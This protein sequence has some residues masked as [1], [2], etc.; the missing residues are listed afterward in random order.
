[1]YNQNGLNTSLNLSA[2]TNMVAGTFYHVVVTFDGTTA[3]VYVNG[4]LLK[5]GAP[6]SYV[7]G[8]D[9]ELTIGSRSDGGFLWAGKAD[10]VAFYGSVLPASEIAA[11]YEAASTNAAS[12]AT[13]IQASSP[14]IYYR[15]NEA[16]DPGA[17]NIGSYGAQANGTYLYS[18]KPG[19]AGPTAA[20]LEASNK[21]TQFDGSGGS[22][23][24]PALPLEGNEVT[25]T[26][27]VKVTGSQTN[28]AGIV[29]NT[30]A[31]SGLRMGSA[32]GYELGYDWNGAAGSFVSQLN[33]VDGQWCFVGLI[34]RPDKA[35]LC[36][37][38]GTTFSTAENIFA[39]EPTSWS[40][41]SRI[42]NAGAAAVLN[43]SIDEVTLFDR[44]LGIGD[45]YSQYAAAVGGL[46]PRI[47]VE[48]QTP[49]ST[50][51]QYDTV[52]LAVDAGGTP[53][54]TYQWRKGLQPIDGA[55]NRTYVIANAQAADAGSYDVVITNP[56]GSATSQ[57]VTIAVTALTAPAIS[58]EPVGRT[59][60]EGGTIKLE[61][62]ASGGGLRYQW[63]KGGQPIET[64][65][66]AIYR[67]E[68]AAAADTGS[69]SL[70]SRTRLGRPL[71]VQP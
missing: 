7:P 17:A 66:N 26:A 28:S 2:D 56:Y 64:A 38:D 23:T 24:L 51:Y 59:L 69:Y 14:L 37:Q 40:S 15:F 35:I 46:G 57:A 43:G 53:T 12:Y 48:P 11:H 39:N 10:E 42:G 30:A 62:V 54:L 32:G 65:T 44:A 45:V 25:L 31:S 22:V 50:V 63:S 1:M 6:T 16:G 4:V 34:V 3:R 8:V 18:A 13:Q 60:Y 33:L 20:N 70:P 21:A 61:V 52:A 9:G 58:Q 41:K 19:Q 49:A 67:V 29:F 55:T 5:S 71:R 68:S 36:L 27:W 47:F